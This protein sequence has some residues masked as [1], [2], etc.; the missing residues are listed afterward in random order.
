MIG[1]RLHDE[2]HAIRVG[3][4]INEEIKRRAGKRYADLND[5]WLKLS[6]MKGDALVDIDDLAKQL[7]EIAEDVAKRYRQY[8]GGRLPQS[9]TDEIA[10]LEARARKVQSRA[11]KIQSQV[12]LWR[13]QQAEIRAA[14]ASLEQEYVVKVLS[15]VREFGGATRLPYTSRIDD[16]RVLRR[17]S[18]AA[19][20]SKKAKKALEDALELFPRDWLEKVQSGPDLHVSFKGSRGF[21]SQLKAYNTSVITLPS[22]ASLKNYFPTAFDRSRGKYVL[23]DEGK[24][25]VTESIRK[26]AVHEFSHHMEEVIPDIVRLER[27]FYRRRTAGEQLEWL[28]RPYGRHETYRPDKW[29]ERYMGR[30]YIDRGTGESAFYEILSMAD[31]NILAGA[32]TEIDEET[33]EFILGLLAGAK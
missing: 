19:K 1:D 10:A 14:Q 21:H 12:E 4:R 30:E 23:T 7:D 28:G 32:K 29:P 5:E 18:G 15:E 8:P 25:L 27:E 17:V 33:R 2:Q 9:V 24:K 3:R 20:S 13:A 16:N 31:E 6:R 26:T 11:D 22:E